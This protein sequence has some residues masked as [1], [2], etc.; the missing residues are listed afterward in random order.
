MTTFDKN[1]LFC[2]IHL[3]Y[4]TL[5]IVSVCAFLITFKISIQI[6][7]HSADTFLMYLILIHDY[8]VLRLFCNSS[9]CAAHAVLLASFLWTHPFLKT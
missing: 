7:I 5:F 8:T 6:F 2:P 3:L 9:D 4:L 1:M